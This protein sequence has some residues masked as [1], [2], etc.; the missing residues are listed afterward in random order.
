VTGFDVALLDLGLPGGNGAKLKADLREANPNMAVLV[1]SASFKPQNAE[2]ITKSGAEEVLDKL[3]SLSGYVS[4]PRIISLDCFAS[5]GYTLVNAPRYDGCL[6]MAFFDGE[7]SAVRGL[8]VS[9]AFFA[10]S[11]Q[12]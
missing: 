2:R 5:N 8:H 7:D 1:L 10:A 12:G 11:I 6:F 9:L 4:R 3:A